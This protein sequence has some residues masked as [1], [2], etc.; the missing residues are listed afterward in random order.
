VGK[1]SVEHFPVVKE[2]DVVGKLSEFS[3]KEVNPFNKLLKTD[4]NFGKFDVT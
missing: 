1:A 4:K 2:S 3:L